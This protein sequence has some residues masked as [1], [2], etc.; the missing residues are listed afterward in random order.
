MSEAPKDLILPILIKIQEDAAA[1]RAEL[2][3]QFEAM[4]ADV[5]ARFDA[6]DVQ[7]RRQRF[8]S[9]GMLVM[10]RGTVGQFDERVAALEN[11]VAVLE[12]RPS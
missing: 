10:M 1:F 8:D 7:F 12:R 2:R 9:A 4:K 6:V 5:N 11:R 3:A